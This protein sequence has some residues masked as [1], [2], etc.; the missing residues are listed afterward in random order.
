[1]LS[2][3]RLIPNVY[4]NLHISIAF[5]RGLDMIPAEKPPSGGESQDMR[6][7]KIR[8]IE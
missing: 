5:L 4:L 7:V 3:K 8:S 2:N 6:W 1:M